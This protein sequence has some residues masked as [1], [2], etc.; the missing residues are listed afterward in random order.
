MKLTPLIFVSHSSELN[1][2]ELM[3]IE[4]VEYLNPQRFE[5]ILVAPREGALLQRARKAGLE[6]KV[7]P[8]KWWIT[9]PTQ[10][11]RQ[12]LNWCLNLM[13]LFQLVRFVKSKSPRVVISNSSV[14]LGGALA[15]RLIKVPHFWIIH[16]LLDHPQAVVKFIGGNRLLVKLIGWLSNLIIANSN[17]TA[18]PFQPNYPVKIIFN[19]VDLKAVHKKIQNLFANENQQTRRP[20]LQRDMLEGENFLQMREIIKSKIR[21]QRQLGTEDQLLGV[22]GKFKWE[23]GQDIALYAL[24]ELKNTFSRLKLIFIGEPADG[25]YYRLMKKLINKL[26]LEKRVVFM[27][28]VDELYALLPALDILVVSS[29]QESFGR[30]IL[31]AMA[32]GVP[33]VAFNQGG[34]P[35]IIEDGRNGFLA[36]NFSSQSLAE[37]IALL[38]KNPEYE[39]NF[40]LQGYQTVKSHFNLD[41]QVKNFEKILDRWI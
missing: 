5:K 23:K 36:K 20:S 26:G 6:T 24:A 7:I 3:L 15:A 39:E 21:Q 11:W 16:E 2:A 32:V 18:R 41:E 38:L 40:A 1:G 29:R 8:Q 12:P 33:V 28:Y 19:G 25:N 14:A 30:V 34:I 22:V 17:V 9:S 31:E 37:K 10:R 13:G 27:G 4:L 35:E